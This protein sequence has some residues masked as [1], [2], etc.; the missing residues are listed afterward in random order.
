MVWLRISKAGTASVEVDIDRYEAWQRKRRKILV[1]DPPKHLTQRPVP[2]EKDVWRCK[3][4]S[5][6]KR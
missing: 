5:G 1:K 3:K 2:P 6:L 4:D